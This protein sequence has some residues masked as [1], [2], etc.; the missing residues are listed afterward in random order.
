M[1]TFAMNVYKSEQVHTYIPL[2]FYISEH[3]KTTNVNIKAMKCNL[4]D[5]SSGGKEKIKARVINR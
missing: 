5:Q 1:E 4:K 3:T 2:A